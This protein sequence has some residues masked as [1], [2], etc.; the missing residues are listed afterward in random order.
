M[1]RNEQKEINSMA[2]DAYHWAILEL[3][4]GVINTDRLRTCKAVVHRCESLV[5]L[6]SY[7]SIVAAIGPYGRLYDFLRFVY[8]YTATSAHHISKFA[9]DYGAIERYTYREIDE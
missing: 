4:R 8:G 1:T 6:Q 9:K 2:V 3:K 7:D 5:I